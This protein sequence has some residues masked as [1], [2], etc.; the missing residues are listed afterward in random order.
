MLAE[1][2]GVIGWLIFDHPE[3]LNAVNLDMWLE[4]D[5]M[6]DDFAKDDAV[7]VVVLRGAGEKAFV[8]GGD[9]SKFGQHRSSAA[10]VAESNRLTD[11]MRKKLAEFAKPTI[12]MIHGY[13]LGGG[14]AIALLCDLRI[15]AEGSTFSI[16]AARLGIGYAPQSVGML[17]ALVGP[18]F[19]R[20]ILFTG[21]RF[22]AEEALQMGLLNRLLP[23][24]EL[25]AY[26]REYADMIG[27][28]APLS[29]QASKLAS[30]ELLKDEAERDLDM[31]QRVVDA[32]FDSQDYLEGRTAFMEKRQPVF[33]GQ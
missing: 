31:S 18:A 4:L 32:C 11:P 3:R 21:R 28:N 22:T 8:S 33:R 23:R 27:K 16:P 12:A 10:A 30:I 7:R 29:L 1:K 14:L 25:E 13:C 20:E 17:Q 6:L 9:I 24:E 26:V 5:H 19:A 15:A 2:E